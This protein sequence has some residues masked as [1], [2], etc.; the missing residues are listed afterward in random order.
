VLS[1]GG[2]LDKWLNKTGIEE[3]SD[4]NLENLVTEYL[5]LCLNILYQFFLFVYKGVYV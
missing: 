2:K 5:E 4:R 1:K 3:K